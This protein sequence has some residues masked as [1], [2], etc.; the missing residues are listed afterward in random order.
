[1]SLTPIT[2]P[3]S[4]PDK[5]T[6]FLHK[7]TPCLCTFHLGFGLVR[8]APVAWLVPPYHAGDAGPRLP[9]NSQASG[10][11]PG[12]SG[13]KGGHRCRDAGLIPI[14]VPEVRRLLTRLVWTGNH[15]ADFVLSWSTWRRRHQARSQQCHYKRRQSLLAS[16][17]DQPL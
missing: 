5:V 11:D 9:V 3:R 15:P 1:M 2:I 6:S 12:M 7:F 10:V 13:R 14:T 17:V 8:G 16:L 4:F